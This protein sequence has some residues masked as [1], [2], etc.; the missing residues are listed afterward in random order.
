MRLAL[1]LATALPRPAAIQ[2]LEAA[3]QARGVSILDFKAFSNLSLAVQFEASA[4][5]LPAAAADL[6]AGGF[7]LAASSREELALLAAAPGDA[8]IQGTLQVTFAGGDGSMEVIVPAVP[9]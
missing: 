7:L 9:G 5:A 2:A 6:S 4:Q 1:N 3:C 8:E